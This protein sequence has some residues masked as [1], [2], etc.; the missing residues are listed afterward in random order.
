MDAIR[1]SA[2]RSPRAFLD[3]Q[4]AFYDGDPHYVPPLTMA[5]TWQVDRKKNPFFRH[6]DAEF[7]LAERGGEVVGRVSA[8]RNHLHDDFHGDRVGFFGHFE[9]RDEG[10]A[11]ALLDHA[12]AWLAARGATAMRGPVDLSTN[13]RCGVLLPGGEPG[14]PVVMMPYNP[15]SYV[16]WLESYGLAKAKDL[17]ALMLV[18]YTATAERFE[19]LIARITQ[20]T[21]AVIRQVDLRRFDRELDILWDLYQRIW[22]RNWGFVPMLEDEFRRSSTELKLIARRE[23]L[24][25][26]EIEGKPVAFGINVPDVNVGIAACNGRLLPFGW[27]KL[28]RA[29]KKVDRTRV[30]LLGV[31]PEHRKSGLDAL[32]LHHYY[33]NNPGVGCPH[34]E[35]SWILEDNAEMLRVLVSLGGHEYR[36]YR[37]YETPLT[38]AAR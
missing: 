7:W 8:V 32:L 25:I 24:V 17:L 3:A 1:F 23:L 21:G 6:A 27:W 22:N 38:A 12:K 13:Y 30:L 16:E 20:R 14:P 31:V 5:E 19:R 10:A 36:R 11:H 28:F 2:A 9:A 4:R 26:V 35:A 37:I 33:V 18:S 29:M 34:C 15:P